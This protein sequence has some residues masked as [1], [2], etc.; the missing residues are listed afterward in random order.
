MHTGLVRTTGVARREFLRTTL[1]LLSAT[2]AGV[3][4][5]AFARD[6]PRTREALARALQRETDAH[7]R[8][9]VFAERAAADGYRGIAYM[10]NAF[11]T[12][13]GVHARNFRA[14]LEGLGASTEVAPTPISP[15]TTK[16][17]LIAAVADEIDSID[18]LYPETLKRIEPEGHE[19]ARAVV[20][21]AWESERQHRD[22]IRKIQLYSPLLFERVAREIDAKTGLYFVCMTCGSTRNGKPETNCPVCA[23]PAE[24]YRLVPVPA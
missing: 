18:A 23:S 22:L 8:Y 3:T 6:Y 4:S 19:R 16:E 2:L 9:V 10:F 15:G 1:S 21:F 13:E 7:R 24:R 11:A 14:L 17:N 20:G 5:R 12:S